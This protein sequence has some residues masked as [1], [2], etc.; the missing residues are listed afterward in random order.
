M[1]LVRILVILTKECSVVG[2]EEGSVAIGAEGAVIGYTR[3]LTL[4][5]EIVS[6]FARERLAVGDGILNREGVGKRAGET[7]LADGS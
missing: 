6:A 3:D 5:E 2:D 4:D 7:H 1:G